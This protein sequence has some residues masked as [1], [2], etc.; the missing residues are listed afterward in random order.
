MQ[1]GVRRAALPAKIATH[2]IWYVGRHGFAAHLLENGNNIRV[3]QKLM[4]PADVKTTEIYIQVRQRDMG[5]R[6]SPVDIF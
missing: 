2:V 3:V 5:A 1:K 4:G 6:Q